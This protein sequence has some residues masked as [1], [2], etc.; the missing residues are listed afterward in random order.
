M[1][2][3][4]KVRRFIENKVLELGNIDKVYKVY[5]D[6]DLVSEYAKRV[7][8]TL[9]QKSKSREFRPAKTQL[10]QTRVRKKQPH[11]ATAIQVKRRLASTSINDATNRY[12][13]DCGKSIPSARLEISPEARRCVQ[14]QRALEGKN[15]S[16]HRRRID[17]GLAGSRDDHKKLK[18]RE[19]GSMVNRNR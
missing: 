13:I 1:A 9:L 16:V 3:E 18:A 7:A 15:P 6:N 19:W 2:L 5:N 8:F 12:C 17:E 11:H 4:K 14:C 10:T